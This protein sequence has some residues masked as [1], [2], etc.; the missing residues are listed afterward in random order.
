MSEELRKKFT[1]E[2]R[3]QLASE[4]ARSGDQTQ[5]PDFDQ[6]LRRYANFRL[7]C[8]Q[9][10]RRRLL[11]SR[12]L[13]VLIASNGLRSDLHAG[14]FLTALDIHSGAD[15]LPRLS[16]A[17][18]RGGYGKLDSLLYDWGINHLHLGVQRQA[19]Q[20]I[21]STNEILFVAFKPSLAYLVDIKPHGHWES[22]DLLE[23]M[24]E[25]WPHLHKGN[26][27]GRTAHAPSSV[28]IKSMRK[29]GINTAV[30]LPNGASYMAQGGGLTSTG[31][32]IR[33]L[34][35]ANWVSASIDDIADKASSAAWLD[36]QGWNRPSPNRSLSLDGQVFVLHLADTSTGV[37]MDISFVSPKEMDAMHYTG[38]VP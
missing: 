21:E 31:E 36:S 12:K 13:Q 8:P 1:E 28:A 2:V 38:Q 20:L 24:Y 33:A 14:L 6:L 18:A 32:S 23:C 11:W 29:A 25:N 30:R 19:D 37:H 34:M 16:R 10:R 22:L 35:F 15:L 27:I 5:E 4:L 3:Q 7:R 17:F 26:R 9:Q